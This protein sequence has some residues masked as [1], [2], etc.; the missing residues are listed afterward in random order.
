MLDGMNRNNKIAEGLSVK[1][2]NMSFVC[3]CM[4]VLFHA[5]PAP[6]MGSFAWW[7]CHVVGREG[8]CMIAVPWFFLSSGFFLASHLGESE[9]WWQREVVKRIRSLV[10]PFYIWMV[11]TVLFG[12]A[13]WYMKVHVFNMQVKG[14]PFS[15]PVGIF[16]LKMLGLHPFEDIGVF[17]YVRCLFCLVLISPILYVMTKWK[18][19]VLTI[20]TI[21]FLMVSWCFTNG[22]G[23][24]FYFFFDRFFSIRGLL[25][26]F[27]G[28]LLRF[29]PPLLRVDRSIA[30][31]SLAFGIILLVI[32]NCI[33]KGGNMAWMGIFEATLVPFILVG[34]FGIMTDL[35]FPEWVVGG[36]FPIFLMH[37]MFLSLSSLGF[38]VLGLYGNPQYDLFMMF[39][40]AL[41]AIV[42]SIMISA[43]MHR[44]FPR[45][46]DVIFGGR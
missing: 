21:L 41:V 7:I 38:K 16:A 3:A 44:Y 13:I 28:I 17:W 31:V 45:V 2:A 46:S 29:Q 30:V 5:T 12:I 8:I 4:I 36:S 20:L 24:E 39:S 35:R 37:N 19:L 22:A 25:Y 10:V 33:M 11:V 6:Q 14:S 34:T 27:I 15:L 23:K 42:A 32:D 9:R 26:F 1:M 18:W 43:F 40:R